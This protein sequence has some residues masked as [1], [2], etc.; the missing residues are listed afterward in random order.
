MQLKQQVAATVSFRFATWTK[1]S[2]ALSA[3]SQ[4]MNLLAPANTAAAKGSGGKALTAVSLAGEATATLLTMSAADAAR[5]C[6][7]QIVAVDRDYS[8]QIGYVGAP[9]S[10]AYVRSAA[11]VQNDPDFVRRVTFNLGRVAKVTTAGLTLS[12]PLPAGSPDCSMRV[13]AVLGFVDREGGSF[14]QEWSAL[15]VMQG[16]QGERIL[17][18]YPRLQA[19]TGALESSEPIIP[20]LDRQALCASFRAFPVVDGNDGE[21]ALCYRSFLPAAMTQS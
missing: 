4:H 12:Q 1:L 6:V 16:E 21:Q 3:G 17:F 9:I 19:M 5:F 20:Q 18:H 11:A 2:M 7:G 8:G 13:Q 14:I 10:A 15:F